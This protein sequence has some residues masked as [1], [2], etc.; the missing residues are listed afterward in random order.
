M[1]HILCQI[2]T[3]PNYIKYG[4]PKD[5]FSNW[6]E[7]SILHALGYNVSQ[8]EGLTDL[9]RKVILERIIDSGAMTKDRVLSYLDFF[10]RM[11]GGTSSASEKWKEDRR[12]IAAYN[13]GSNIRIPIGTIIR[14]TSCDHD[15]IKC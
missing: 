11:H 13:L 5:G 9:Q 1:G 15:F 14:I 10:V 6:R 8:A 4:P 12:Y 2:E 7:E 3:Y